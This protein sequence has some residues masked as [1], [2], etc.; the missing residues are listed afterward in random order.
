MFM[1]IFKTINDYDNTAI[2]NL[3]M[4]KNGDVSIQTR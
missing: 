2:H 1:Q 3:L 4:A